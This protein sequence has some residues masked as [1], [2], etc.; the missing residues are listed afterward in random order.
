MIKSVFHHRRRVAHRGRDD[1][2]TNSHVVSA[3]NESQYNLIKF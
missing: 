3:S 2:T 1:I